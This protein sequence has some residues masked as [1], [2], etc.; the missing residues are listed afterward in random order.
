MNGLLGW[1]YVFVDLSI[2]A[3]LQ[4]SLEHFDDSCIDELSGNIE[5]VVL[6]RGEIDQRPKSGVLRVY[7]GDRA[8][9]DLEETDMEEELFGVA[10]RCVGVLFHEIISEDLLYDCFELS[11]VRLVE[12]VHENVQL[13]N[14]LSDSH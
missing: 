9:D 11:C 4:D 2:R 6:Q 5:G 13:V 10:D 8:L 14:L 7:R 12:V 3:V 1:A